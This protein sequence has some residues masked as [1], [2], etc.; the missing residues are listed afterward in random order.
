MPTVPRYGP[1]RV[2]ETPLPNARLTARVTPEALGAGIGQGLTEVG[3]TIEQERK[4]ADE[5]MVLDADRELGEFETTTLYD[6]DTGALT[7]R[8]RDAFTMP[9]EVQSSYSQKVAEL[10][11]RMTSDD[12][13]LK[14][15]KL[16]VARE[17][18]INRTVQKH[19]ASEIQKFEDE[20]TDSYIKNSRANAA[21][22]YNDPERVSMEISRQKMALSA[23]AKR[24]GLPSEWTELKIKNAESQTHVSVI[25]RMLNNNQDRMAQ[26]YFKE[27]K[28]GITGEH[29]GE[30]EKA[31]DAATLRGESQRAA[32]KI[33]LTE[34]DYQEQL[35]KARQIRDPKVRDDVVKRVNQRNAEK[36]TA[37]AQEQRQAKDDSW[38]IIASGKNQ[39]AIPATT[40]SKL[41]G[42][43]QQAIV[44]FMQKRAS[45]EPI[46]TDW[47]AYYGLA[48][49]DPKALSAVNLNDFRNKLSN[50]EF[51]Q[52][53]GWQRANASALQKG[54][55]PE[56]TTQ[57]LINAALNEHKMNDSLKGQFTSRVYQ[58]IDDEQRAVNRKLTTK[59]RRQIIDNLMI[60]GE[61][62]RD[63]LWDPNK[64]T[65][66]IE[67]NEER[68]RFYVKD[69]PDTEREKIEAALRRQQIPVT[70]EN[71]MRLYNQKLQMQ[72]LKG[73]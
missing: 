44:S 24:N 22:N 50:T 68:R 73:Q 20:S 29:V 27:N 12:A 52:V 51:K 19:V 31:L 42:T 7:K 63:W 60:E 62:H 14:F 5:I 41:N 67:T 21:F 28:P 48:R 37:T 70:D 11:G 25:E 8:G 9:E 4:K 26:A 30:V 6:P 53:V 33:F 43:D 40:W 10:E 2:Q 47:E 56:G 3:R 35:K 65:F 38:E 59:E 15:R 32:D 72:I 17:R 39:D 46:L 66:E 49:L 55:A 71:V 45:G 54:V 34:D 16:S 64:R 23:Y 61:V 18:G 69:V 13:K 1:Q 57:Q 58:T 36:N